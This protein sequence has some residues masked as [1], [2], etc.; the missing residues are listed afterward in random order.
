MDVRYIGKTIRLLS[1]RLSKHICDSKR[2][3]KSGTH[4]SCWIRSVGT[5][6]IK[7]LV[8][9]PEHF[10]SEMERRVIALYR[11]SGFRLVNATDGGEGCSGYRATEETKAKLRKARAKWSDETRVKMIASLRGHNA[12]RGAD[13]PLFGKPRSP[14]VC[15]K[16]SAA[17]KGHYKNPP[18]SDET[19]ARQRESAIVG[20]VKRRQGQ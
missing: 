1:D 15:A 10:G 9:V 16:I 5:P 18:I 17:K 8:I 12:S 7:A 11:T 3:T 20:W 4:R 19:R 6:K 13:N 2:K 14:E